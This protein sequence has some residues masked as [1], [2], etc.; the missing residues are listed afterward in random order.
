PAQHFAIAPF[1]KIV[2]VAAIFAA[3]MML[4]PD[5]AEFVGE[6]EQKLIAV[7]MPDSEEGECLP[8]ERR[9]GC[10]LVRPCLEILRLIGND[11]QRDIVSK[12]PFAEIAPREHRAVDQGIAGGWRVTVAIAADL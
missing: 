6:R 11:V 8:D 10:D 1:G 7:E 9:V 12:V 5:A 2:G 3:A 4:K